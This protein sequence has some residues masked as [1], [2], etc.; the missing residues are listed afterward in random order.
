MSG[1][2]PYLRLFDEQRALIDANSCAPLNARRDD[3]R[4]FLSGAVLPNRNT[5][6]YK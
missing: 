5:E 1:L 2:Q 4:R 3:A 6:P